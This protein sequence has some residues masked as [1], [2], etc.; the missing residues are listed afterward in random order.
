MARPT[1]RE[2]KNYRHGTLCRPGECSASSVSGTLDALARVVRPF[3]IFHLLM[4]L[5]VSL[6]SQHPYIHATDRVAMPFQAHPLI[7]MVFLPVNSLSYSSEQKSNNPSRHP[8]PSNTMTEADSAV[9]SLSPVYPSSV[10]AR[11][12]T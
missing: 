12:L 7:H 8:C 11:G 6:Y 9:R 10:S 4:P 2:S 5:H 3:L 1:A